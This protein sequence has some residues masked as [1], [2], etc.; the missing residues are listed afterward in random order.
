MTSKTHL[1]SAIPP[2][3]AR[4]TAV[5]IRVAA[6]A[7]HEVAVRAYELFLKDGSVDVMIWSIGCLRK[8]N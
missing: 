4:T 5:E 1:V 3:S 8:R 7:Q 2:A 6:P